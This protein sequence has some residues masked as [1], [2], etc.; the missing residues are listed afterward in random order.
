MT[1]P[2]TIPN[3]LAAGDATLS[4][5]LGLSVTYNEWHALLLGVAIGR[6][7][8]RTGRLGVALTAVVTA[9]LGVTVGGGVGVRTAAREPWW[10]AVGCLA[11][12]RGP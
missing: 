8:R 6:L 3:R 2:D 4:T 10:F 11:G 7:A 9:T 1:Q 5:P 12:V